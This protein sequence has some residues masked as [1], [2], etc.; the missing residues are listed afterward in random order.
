MALDLKEIEDPATEKRY[1][2]LVNGDLEAVSGA[3]ECAQRIKV[4]LN[5][6]LG[7]YAFDLAAGLPIFDQIF[8]RQQYDNFVKNYYRQGILGVNNVT[9]VQELTLNRGEERN[10]KMKFSAV[11]E[12]TTII[13]GE[14]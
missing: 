8:K 4:A 6:V 13:E 3:E 14:V 11:Y 5:K 1:L 9:A 7:E 12:G 2:S 10:Y